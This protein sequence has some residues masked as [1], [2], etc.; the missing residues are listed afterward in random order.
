M[1]L[2]IRVTALSAIAL[3]SSMLTFGYGGQTPIR[4]THTEQQD[5][6][7]APRAVQPGKGGAAWRN[8]PVEVNESRVQTAQDSQ[9]LRR[10][11]AVTPS[12]SAYRK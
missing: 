11:P 2:S 1:K 4:P 12:D 5:A 8:Q 6:A 9:K 10:D 7:G 3:A